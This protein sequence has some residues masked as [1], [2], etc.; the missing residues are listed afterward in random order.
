MSEQ[1]ALGSHL[2]LRRRGGRA[3]LE[4]CVG[5]QRLFRVFVCQ[6]SDLSVVKAER[7]TGGSLSGVCT[8]LT[9]RLRTRSPRGG[10]G[11]AAVT[12]RVPRQLREQGAGDE[13]QPQIFPRRERW[14]SRWEIKPGPRKDTASKGAAGLGRNLEGA[15]RLVCLPRPVRA[16]KLCQPCSPRGH[17]NVSKELHENTQWQFRG[18]N[19]LR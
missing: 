3:L 2:G 8:R 6:Q 19:M 12:G 14:A 11:P 7:G 16:R 4:V 1:A 15:A 17:Q 5:S 10:G 18:G 13:Q 9:G